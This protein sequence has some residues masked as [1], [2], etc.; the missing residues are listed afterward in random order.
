ARRILN[1]DW[2]VCLRLS[3]IANLA[4]TLLGIPFT[5]GIMVGS[6][7]ALWDRIDNVV[8][9]MMTGHANIL[10]PKIVELLL[11][12]PWL[13]PDGRDMYWMLPCAVLILCVPFFFVSVWSENFVGRFCV[14]TE[15]KQLV[16]QWAWKANVVSYCLMFVVTLLLLAA[17][18][19]DHAV[20]L[21]N[22]E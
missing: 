17:S 21:N 1:S 3:T 12:F 20:T 9:G 16:S 15:Q 22:E 5:Y 18:V 6:E 4:S 10:G 2:K 7:L 8:Q 13:P 14:A 11:M 19:I